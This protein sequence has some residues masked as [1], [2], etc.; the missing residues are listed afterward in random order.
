MW[1]G[2]CLGNHSLV[3]ASRQMNFS[4]LEGERI[5]CVLNLS[6]AWRF[7][8]YTEKGQAPVVLRTSPIVCVCVCLPLYGLSLSLSPSLSLSLSVCSHVSKGTVKA[9]T[10]PRML[11]EAAAEFFGGMVCGKALSA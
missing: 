1:L 10:V 2:L 5:R 11:R 9:G 8:T 7:C 6:Q 4:F 3:C